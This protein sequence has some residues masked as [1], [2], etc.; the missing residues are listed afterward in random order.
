MGIISSIQALLQEEERVSIVPETRDTSSM[1]LNGRQAFSLLMG[2]EPTA[3]GASINERTALQIS[4][5]SPSVR[6]IAET[7]GSLPL[8]IYE[9]TA[10]GERE[11]TDHSLSYLLGTEPN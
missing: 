3:S 10:D 8:K 5:V 7:A 11:A 6:V 9:Q 4:W 2:G 1:L